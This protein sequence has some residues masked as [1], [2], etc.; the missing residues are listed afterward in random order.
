MGGSYNRKLWARAWLARHGIF[1]IGR[2]G[3]WSYANSDACIHE[4]MELAATLLGSRPSRRR[5]G[6]FKAC[7]AA[8]MRRERNI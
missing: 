7:D 5:A 6:P 3:G 8:T 4:A 2:F 1:T